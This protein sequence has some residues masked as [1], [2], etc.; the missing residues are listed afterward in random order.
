LYSLPD[1]EG[2]KSSRVRWTGYVAFME[3]MKNAY[4]I[5]VTKPEGKRPL[6]RPRLRQED[7]INMDLK[8]CDWMYRIHMAQGRKQ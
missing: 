5:L 3:G 8:L 7:D 6:L 2:I 1:N 4:K